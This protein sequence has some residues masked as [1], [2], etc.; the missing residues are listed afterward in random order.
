MERVTFNW[1]RQIEERRTEGTLETTFCGAMLTLLCKKGR[2]RRK[3]SKARKMFSPQ[4][5]RQSFIPLF[6][7]HKKRHEAA[8]RKGER[9]QKKTILAGL[10]AYFPKEKGDDGNGQ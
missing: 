4:K 2:R 1:G 3:D 9:R 10:K 8:P 6:L 7:G 5:K